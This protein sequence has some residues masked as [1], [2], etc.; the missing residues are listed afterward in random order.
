[1][2]GPGAGNIKC[3]IVAGSNP[4]RVH[5][6]A[7]GEAR[8]AGGRD[9]SWNLTGESEPITVPVMVFRIEGGGEPSY[10]ASS[11]TSRRS[12]DVV[13]ERGSHDRVSLVLLAVLRRRRARTTRGR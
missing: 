6:L 11:T 3:N 9:A 13:N 8:T 4:G 7:L 2:G 1:M 10:R 5:P 12:G